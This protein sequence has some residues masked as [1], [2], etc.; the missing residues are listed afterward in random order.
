MVSGRVIRTAAAEHRRLHCHKVLHQQIAFWFRRQTAH[1]LVY[2]QLNWA[3]YLGSLNLKFD[4]SSIS[5]KLMSNCSTFE[6]DRKL[7]Y[8]KM[9]S[10]RILCTEKI[11]MLLRVYVFLAHME[12]FQA[13]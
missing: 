10:S 7:H 12:Q 8:E 1:S 5:I 6:N 3:H 9:K 4:N 11:Q 13:G 2:S